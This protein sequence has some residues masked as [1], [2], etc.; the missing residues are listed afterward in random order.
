MDKAV[1]DLINERFDKLDEKVDKV[2]TT[3]ETRAT[4]CNVAFRQKTSNALFRWAIGLIVFGLFAV[5][6]VTA[7]NK[8]HLAEIDQ[9]VTQMA[10]EV[11]KIYELLEE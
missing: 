8:V 7:A 1:I 4:H 11:D 9:E 10:K 6:G 5:G 3:C 2:R